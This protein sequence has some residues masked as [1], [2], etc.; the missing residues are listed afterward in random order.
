MARTRIYA[1]TPVFGGCL[2][3]EFAAD[4]RRIMDAVQ[5]GLLTII[6]SEVVLAELQTAPEAV[7]RALAELP[8]ESVEVIELTDDVFDL[9]AAYLD[10]GILPP[11][12]ADDAL[13]VAAATV[14]RADAIVSWNFSHIVRLDK[15]KAYNRVNFELRYGIL[16]ILSPKEVI[17]DDD[18]SG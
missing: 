12:W 2:D 6:V 4:S 14:S 11:R 8:R 1:D 18:T 7:R 5:R 17:V 16:T 3:S 9:Q 13:H 15:I 10:A